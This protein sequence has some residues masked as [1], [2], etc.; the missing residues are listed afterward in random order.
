MRARTERWPAEKTAAEKAAAEKAAAEKAAAEKAAVEKAA[1]EKA[2]AEKAAAE[3]AAAEKAAAE[4]AAAA[5]AAKK[6][7]KAAKRAAKEAKAAAKAEAT[8]ATATTAG[9]SVRV[10]YIGDEEAFDGFLARSAGRLLAVDFTATWCGPCQQI[11][12]RFEAMAAEWPNVV[13]AKVDVDDADGVAER[14]GVTAMPT[15][16]FYRSGAKVAEL[17][18]AE[19]DELRALLLKHGTATQQASAAGP[20]SDDTQPRKRDGEA[21]ATSETA[22][23]G[24]RHK[25]DASA[26]PADSGG[27]KPIK[28][29]KIISKEL[30]TCGGK[31]GLKALRKACV[32]EARAHPTHLGRDKG[33]LIE[34][35]DRLLPTFKKYSMVGGQVTFAEGGAA[36][37]D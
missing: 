23:N 20:A 25:A 32:A 27:K 30:Q 5:K 19:E 4:E 28:W 33:E 15:F 26:A 36:D 37:A 11:G 10:P 21:A 29:K 7:A 3:K 13:F 22:A 24:K 9:K 6:E 1:A 18:G 34:E 12:P 16:Q 31:M 14:C 17:C 35:F 2:A 8:A